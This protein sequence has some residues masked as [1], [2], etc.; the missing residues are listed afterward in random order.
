MQDKEIGKQRIMD[1]FKTTEQV[2]T[3]QRIQTVNKIC[4]RVM[5]TNSGFLEFDSNCTLKDNKKKIES[6]E[7]I[8]SL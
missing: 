1:L 8:V 5:L 6:I 2:D 3:K 4:S 7:N